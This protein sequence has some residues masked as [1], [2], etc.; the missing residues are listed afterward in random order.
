MS[1][2]QRNEIFSCLLTR[3]ITRI[4]DFVIRWKSLYLNFVINQIFMNFVYII[5]Y[6]FV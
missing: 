3:I 5:S 1:M 2:I 4:L 6:L